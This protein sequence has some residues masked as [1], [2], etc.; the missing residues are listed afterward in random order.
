ME[1]DKRVASENVGRKQARAVPRGSSTEVDRC[2]NSP[3]HHSV[4]TTRLGRCPKRDAAT[5]DDVA[6]SCKT[7]TNDIIVIKATCRNMHLNI[8]LNKKQKN[9]KDT[10]PTS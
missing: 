5:D 9:S 10:S 1:T 4:S 6:N 3:D 7:V 2:G 8:Y